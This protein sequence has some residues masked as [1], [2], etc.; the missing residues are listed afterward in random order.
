M[1][2][3][4]SSISFDIVFAA[5][6]MSHNHDSCRWLESS[7]APDS[8]RR[9]PACRS[10][11]RL[12]IGASPFRRPFRTTLEPTLVSVHTFG[13]FESLFL[14]SGLFMPTAA[15]SSYPPPPILLFA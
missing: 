1:R 13:S 7:P 9:Q 2:G 12:V 14:E 6:G 11:A 4:G 5:F 10:A 8:T 15:Q 3:R